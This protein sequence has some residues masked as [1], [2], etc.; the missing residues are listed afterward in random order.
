R[1][2][3]LAPAIRS[4]HGY[5]GV[6]KRTAA[7]G[8]AGIV[9]AAVAIRAAMPWFVERYVNRQLADIGDYSGH[10]EDVDLALLRGAY[11]LHDLILV[12]VASTADAP[13]LELPVMDISL[14]WRALLDGELVGVLVV[15]GPLV[16]WVQG[17]ADAGERLGS[18]LRW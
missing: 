16:D 10:V 17:G 2:T 7:G 9:L 3:R 15:R 14:E 13:F 6:H 5:A 18:G 11:T 8:I 4:V 12:K 1:G